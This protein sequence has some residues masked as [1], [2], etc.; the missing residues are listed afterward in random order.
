MKQPIYNPDYPT[1]PI[2]F[3]TICAGLFMLAIGI[4]SFSPVRE[5]LATGQVYSLG[6]V[7][8]DTTMIKRSDSPGTY[9]EMM[10][11]FGF[12]GAAGIGFGIWMPIS[13]IIDYIKRNKRKKV[14]KLINNN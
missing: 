7:W 5:A 12:G 4:M 6:V 14:E 8:N 9:W 2:L 11:L 10:C 3:L 1:L 13:I